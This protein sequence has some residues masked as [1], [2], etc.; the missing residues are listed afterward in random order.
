MYSTDNRFFNV[1]KIG[2]IIDLSDCENKYY[3]HNLDEIQQSLNIYDKIIDT[4]QYE[5]ELN[6]IR[7]NL[8]LK[9]KLLGDF[10]RFY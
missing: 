7:K 9:M 10:G 2:Y 8:V 5:K 4:N 6:I 3:V 1:G